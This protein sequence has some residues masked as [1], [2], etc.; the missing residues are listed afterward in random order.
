M[1]ALQ[2]A[3]EEAWNCLE[4]HLCVWCLDL[5]GSRSWSHTLGLPAPFPDLLPLAGPRPTTGPTLGAHYRC[6]YEAPADTTPT[7]GFDGTQF[8][9]S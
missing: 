8:H 2:R 1:R 9:G 3:C 5:V 6:P 4:V 7:D